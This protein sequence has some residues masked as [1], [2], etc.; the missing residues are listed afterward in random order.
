MIPKLREEKNM[1]K[2][3][4]WLILWM[5]FCAALGLLLVGAAILK[6]NAQE[7]SLAPAP[8]A[9]SAPAAAGQSGTPVPTPVP[10]EMQELLADLDM[11]SEEIQRIV[12]AAG[13]AVK[14]PVSIRQLQARF[15]TKN[16][17]YLAWL[18]ANKIPREWRA[19]GWRLDKWVFIPPPAAPA[20]AAK[21]PESPAPTEKKP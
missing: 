6:L 21:P 5:I 20:P 11:I 3:P 13:D 9:A 15:K 2:F 4:G 12:G 17:R 7:K 16:D 8:P 10:A 18:D 14:I 1:K 19:A